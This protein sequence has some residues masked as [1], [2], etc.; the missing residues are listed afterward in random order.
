MNALK[1]LIKILFLLLVLIIIPTSIYGE[2]EEKT[3][4]ILLISSYSPSFMTFFDQIEGIKSTF[5]DTEIIFDIEFMDS[6][7]FYTE[8]NLKN[9]YVSLKYKLEKLD[10]YDIVIVSDDNALNFIREYQEN[11]FKDVAIVFLGINTKENALEASKDPFITG[12]VEEIILDDTINTAIKLTNS[13]SRIIAITDSTNTGQGDLVSFYKS[14]ENFKNHIFSDLDLSDLSY[15]ELEI[16]LNKITRE[17]IVILLS[18]YRDV[19][20]DSRSFN[21]IVK[22][23]I[24]N[25]DSP[26]YHPYFHGLGQGL[27]GGYLVSHYE[28]G[29]VA[30]D[31]VMSILGGESISDIEYISESPNKHTYDNNVLEKYNLDK[32]LLPKDSLIINYEKSLFERY[33]IYVLSAIIIFTLQ[34]IIIVTLIYTL[35]LKG[36]IQK[37]L[38][39]SHLEIAT[40]NSDILVL[41]NELEIRVAERTEELNQTLDNLHGMQERIKR[42]KGMESFLSLAKG[43]AH[44][45]NTPLGLSLTSSSYLNKV[46]R[47]LETAFKEKS[48]SNKKMHE[49]INKLTDGITIISE[50]TM[51]SV[52][53]VSEIEKFC[54]IESKQ[55]RN[56]FDSIKIL[57]D[58]INK[59]NDLVINLD[60]EKDIYLRIPEITFHNVLGAIIDNSIEFSNAEDLIIDIN[61]EL[62]ESEVVI[63]ISDNGVGM[64]DLVKEEA[65]EPYFSTSPHKLGMG[66]FL[67]ESVIYNN[68]E[69][70][71]EL[72]KNYNSGTRIIIRLPHKKRLSETFNLVSL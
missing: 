3:K 19:N 13:S 64:N 22:M 15:K 72:D 35:R 53:I 37:E 30:G 18:A 16:E 4:R 21:E 40:A 71:L 26:I 31:I 2:H 25:T 42:T 57:T 17:D 59:S 56:L 43:I 10:T 38:E 54:L 28:Q 63:S 68:F 66:L 9:F 70:S 65:L 34:V 20:N 46:V 67:S 29:R 49:S 52:D 48:L 6:K 1:S 62:T 12:V 33:F 32:K 60:I 51:T 44:R 5:D 45:I 55:R 11:L 24:E 41:N 61:V 69:G 36:S 58:E 50:N 7:R 27:I 47:E 14:K 23:L 8:E 39:L